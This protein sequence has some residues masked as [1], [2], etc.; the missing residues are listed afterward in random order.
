[1]N[2]AGVYDARFFE[3]LNALMAWAEE[4]DSCDVPPGEVVVNN[5]TELALGRWVAQMR[6]RGRSGRLSESRRAQLEAIECWDWEPRRRGP[7]GHQQRNAEIRR[8]RA[9]GARLD[10][11]AEQYS[12]SRQRIHQICMA[13]P[14]EDT[15]GS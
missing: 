3:H 13:G 10:D 5:G 9:A 14:D 4:H 11:L 15:T 7:A 1:M 8:L 6:S 2:A 12:L